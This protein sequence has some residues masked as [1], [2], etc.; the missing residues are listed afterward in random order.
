MMTGLRALRV[1]WAPALPPA[2]RV[3]VRMTVRQPPPA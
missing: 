2:L 3:K 1:M